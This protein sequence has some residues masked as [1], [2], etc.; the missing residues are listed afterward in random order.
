[1][2]SFEIIG[3]EP[4]LKKLKS[5]LYATIDSISQ[6]VKYLF[7]DLTNSPLDFI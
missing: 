6:L 5:P 7:F 3:I 1:M 2:P 4:S